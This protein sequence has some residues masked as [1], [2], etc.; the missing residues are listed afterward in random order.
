[1]RPK[2]PLVSLSCATEV[3]V[4]MSFF[5]GEGWRGYYVPRQWPC[6]L[7]ASWPVVKWGKGRLYNAKIA[8]Q[9]AATER[10]HCSA[11]I[12]HASYL[13]STPHKGLTSS[14]GRWGWGGGLP[15]HHGKGPEWDFLILTPV[16]TLT[17]TLVSIH[18][19]WKWTSARHSALLTWMT[20]LSIYNPSVTEL[21]DH[22]RSIQLK[23]AGLS[24]TPR[25]SLSLSL[26]L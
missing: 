13:V 17:Q 7:G 4:Y 24:N 8:T 10:Q 21:A 14:R 9:W 2:Y 12:G 16:L 18:T 5:C 11:V 3:S 15:I 19:L 23:K 26:C 6:L 22:H 25:P 1:M 20:E